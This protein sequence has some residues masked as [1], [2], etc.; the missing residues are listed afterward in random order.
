MVKVK[1]SYTEQD[2]ENVQET[3]EVMKSIFNNVK[4]EHDYTDEKGHK[5]MHLNAI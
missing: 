2:K 5:R 1:I 4:V 3:I